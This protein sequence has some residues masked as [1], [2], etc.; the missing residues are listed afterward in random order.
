MKKKIS[1]VILLTVFI[2]AALSVCA[3]ADSEI[4]NPGDKDYEQKAAELA[5][6]IFSD[7]DFKDHPEL[8]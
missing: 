6:K 5:Q 1:F 4:I 2:L 7:V 3:F 8:S